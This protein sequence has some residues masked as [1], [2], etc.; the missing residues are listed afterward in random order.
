MAPRWAASLAALL[1]LGFGQAQG[2]EYP[3]RSIRVLVPAAPGTGLDLDARAI[4]QKMSELLQQPLVIEN[5][6]AAAGVLAMESA[7]KAAADGYTLVIAGAGPLAAHPYLYTRLPYDPERDFVPVSLMQMVPT[8]LAVHA[9]LG[10]NSV[11]ELLAMARARPGQISFASQG[12]GTYVHLAGELFKTVARVDLKHVPYGSQSPFPD[13]AGGHVQAMFTG[14]A[15][16]FPSVK[17]GKV[18]ILAVSAVQRVSVINDVPTFAE[19]GLPEYEASAWNG[20][21]APRGTPAAIVARL[22]AEAAKAVNHP[23]VKERMLR[24]GGLP[25]GGT[26]E[27]FAIFLRAERAKWGKLIREAGLRMD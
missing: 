7:A 9:S 5:R 11:Q 3:S 25:V 1:L 10:L 2:A 16:L 20:L 6:P 26:S 14:I 13:L 8:V 21:I 12:N 17:S 4:A 23:E 22:N 15:P 19:A 27:E 24:F 18:K